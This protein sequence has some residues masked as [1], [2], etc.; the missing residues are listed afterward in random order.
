MDG[1]TI[2]QD[3]Q[4]HAQVALQ[5]LEKF[6]HLLTLDRAGMDLEIEVPEGHPRDDRQA[7]PT[8]G[9]LED[10]RLSAWGPGSHPVGTGAQP[11]FVNEDDDAAFFAGLFLMRARWFVST[12]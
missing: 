8:K 7:L 1:G 5:G 2:P 11:A 12:R 6:R 4:R 9:L 3:Q 10:R